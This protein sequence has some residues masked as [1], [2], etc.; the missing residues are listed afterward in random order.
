MEEL[1]FVEIV[2][3]GTTVPLSINYQLLANLDTQHNLVLLL[4]LNAQW[5]IIVRL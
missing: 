3:L 4:V 2:Q 5:E 1:L